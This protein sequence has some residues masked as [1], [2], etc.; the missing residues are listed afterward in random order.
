MAISVDTTAKDF[1]SIIDSLIDFASVQY[2]PGASAN[3]VWTDYNVSS[4]SRNWAEIVAYVGDQLMFYMDTQANQAYLRSA[5]IPSFV[6]DIAQ[7]L[8]Y[9]VPTQQSASSK[10]TFTVS[11][12]ATIPAGYV[13]SAA[14]VDYFTTREAV[15]NQAGTVEVD[16]LQGTQFNESFTASGTQSES[17]ILAETD[18]IVDLENANPDLRSP[19]VRVN[20]N[21]Y[22]VVSTPVDLAPNSLSVIRKE[23]PDGRTQLTFGDGVF[24]RRLVANESITV[25]YRTGGGTQGNVEVGEITSLSTTLAN[26][27]SVTN[28]VAAT[29]GTDRLTLQQIKDRV[30]LS[31]KTKAGAVSLSDYSDILVANFPQVLTAKAGLNTTDRGIN[32]NIYVV[33]QADTVTNVTDNRVLFDTLT[34]YIERRKTVGTKFLVKDG[35]PV[36]AL[37]LI[38][39]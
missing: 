36:N 37:S 24:G 6:L 26:V 11:G 25:I 12:P 31:L 23:L 2:G 9:E 20:G 10:A 15:I 8:G 30:P 7:Q 29:G 17:I 27:T 38:H 1:D 32:L 28:L 14:G 34:D 35:E 18:I 13:V 39:I 3:R 21:D 33:P 16:I 4:F 19:I 22:S 5:T